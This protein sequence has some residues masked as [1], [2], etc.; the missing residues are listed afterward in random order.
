MLRQ[1]AQGCL[2]G[3]LIVALTAQA[4]PSRWEKEVAAFETED[5]THPKD[6]GGILFLGSSSIRGWT[7]LK[8]DYPNHS[9]VNRGFGGSFIADSTRL[10]DRLVFPYKPRQIVFYA[11]DNDIANGYSPWHILSDFQE[12]TKTVHARLPGTTIS[13]V[14]IKPSPSRWKFA[15]QTVEANNLIGNFCRRTPGL[16]YID[17][18]HAMLGTDGKPRPEIF[19]SDNLHLNSAGYQLWTVIVRPHLSREP[20]TLDKQNQKRGRT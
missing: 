19:L 18:Y 17:I 10:A 11:G 12:F 15:S 6:K 20:K 16:E 1:I 8:E 14:S 5:R 3:I 13:F 7:S 9:V 2:A 4:K